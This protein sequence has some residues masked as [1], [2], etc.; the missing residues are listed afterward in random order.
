M[1]YRVLHVDKILNVSVCQV[2]VTEIAHFVQ[3]VNSSLKLENSHAR[4]A[5]QVHIQIR[6]V[7]LHALNVQA[8]QTRDQ[9]A[10]SLLPACVTPDGRGP[11]EATRAGRVSLASTKRQREVLTAMPATPTPIRHREA[12]TKSTAC[13]MPAILEKTTTR[14]RRVALASTRYKTG[15]RPAMAAGTTRLQVQRRIHWGRR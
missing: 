4:I 8:N 7:R 6:L 15:L 9:A 5:Q 13:A 2:L 10:L 14:A 12:S 3:L 1:C 11:M